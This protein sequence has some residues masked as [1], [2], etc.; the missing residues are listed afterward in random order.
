M[1]YLFDETL[2]MQTIERIR[3]IPADRE[4]RW[5]KMNVAR[6]LAHCGM[7]FRIALG[8]LE[9]RRSWLGR[10]FGHFARGRFL[11]AEPF[12]RNLPTDKRFRIMQAGAVDMER[13]RLIGL[14]ER[15]AKEGA[16]GC[17]FALHPFFGRLSAE[18]WDLLMW[19]HLNHHLTQF[20]A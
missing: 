11:T 20:E 10:I 13:D 16:R 14:V 18:E 7:P 1:A 5:G 15:F 2:L 17:M 19:K 3:S 12:P 4:P 6:M 8:E 9:V